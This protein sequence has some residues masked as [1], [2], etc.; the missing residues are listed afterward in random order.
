MIL[1]GVPQ[2]F[3]SFLKK[4][5]HHVTGTGLAPDTNDTKIK[6]DRVAL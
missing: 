1:N 2:H 3:H 6:R 5:V 4:F